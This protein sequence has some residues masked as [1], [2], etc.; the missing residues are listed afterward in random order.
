MEDKKIKAKNKITTEP[1]GKTVFITGASGFVGGYLR[2]ELENTGYRVLG[3]DLRSGDAEYK[4]DITDKEAVRSVIGEVK[5]NFLVHLAGFASVKES[6]NK[7]E[8]CFKI[9]VDGTR[10]ILDAVRGFC[11]K[12]KILAIS[13]G[14]TYQDS[15]A[16]LK[17]DDSQDVKS[18]YGESRLAQEKLI[19]SYDDLDWVIT[20][21]F[22]HIG[23]GQ[24]TGF[25]SADFASQIAN[26]NNNK[27][28]EPIINVGNLDGVRDFS[29][30]RDIVVAYRLLL[31]KG[32]SHE[33]YNVC[34]GEE[35]EIRKMLKI[36]LS[37]SDVRIDVVRDP[38]KIRSTDISYNV[39]DNTKITKEIGWKR[40][41]KI[42][43]TLKD[44]YSYW[45]NQNV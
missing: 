28:L 43:E 26:I 34:S 14:D 6:F 5:P 16:K 33:I 45:Q 1:S 37:F 23:P 42:E 25:V 39:G 11:S 20:R 22:P 2:R 13:S 19:Q 3:C 29:D 35:L 8:L 36:L 38:S 12:A 7:P 17:E 21:S 18:P 32:K 4:M 30:V 9:N 10:N 44:I 41:Y 40:K 31:E 24:P 27:N 15:F